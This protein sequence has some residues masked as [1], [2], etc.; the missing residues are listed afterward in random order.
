MGTVVLIPQL[1]RHVFCLQIRLQ[2]FVRQL[3]AEAAFF[4]AAEGA[5]RRRGH[6]IV[7]P[8]DTSFQPFGRGW[9][10]EKT[11]QSGTYDLSRDNLKVISTAQRYS[12]IGLDELES[13]SETT[14]ERTE[15]EATVGI[16]ERALSLIAQSALTSGVVL[17]L[18]YG[19]LIGNAPLI[20]ANC[21]SLV[22]VGTRPPAQ[23]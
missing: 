20:F 3:A 19:L 11:F 14:L 21:V 5:L 8:D 16:V 1:D 6:W 15:S 13:T 10:G 22:L 4:H 12:I 9:D 7:D 17:W 2:T 23:V 18:I